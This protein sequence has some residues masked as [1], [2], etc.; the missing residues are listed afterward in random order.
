MLRSHHKF[1]IVDMWPCPAVFYNM[2][3]LSD[4]LHLVLNGMGE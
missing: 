1:D 3:L 4:G 2:T